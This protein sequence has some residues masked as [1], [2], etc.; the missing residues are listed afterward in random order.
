[1]VDQRRRQLREA[2]SWPSR[3]QLV[4]RE[5]G[6]ARQGLRAPH[7]LL[8][9]RVIGGSATT[10][11]EDTPV[12]DPDTRPAII[13]FVERVN[14]AVGKPS[15]SW[16]PEPASH[17]MAP[18]EHHLPVLESRDRSRMEIAA[19]RALSTY[20]GPVGD[21]IHRELQAFLEFGYRFDDGTGLVTRLVDHLMATALN[22]IRRHHG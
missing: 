12:T 21:L 7:L 10:T 4:I 5:T 15:G 11:K 3:S 20:P 2:R 6:L 16:E 8:G 22:P 17:T 1:M 14:R 13:K 9:L 19:R 18:I